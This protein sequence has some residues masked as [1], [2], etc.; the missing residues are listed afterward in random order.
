MTTP[1]AVSFIPWTAL[2]A[3]G[4]ASTQRNFAKLEQEAAKVSFYSDRAISGPLQT[5]GYARAVLNE[6]IGLYQTPDDLDQGVEARTDRRHILEN[7]DKRIRIILHE[8]AL[9][10]RVG[11]PAVMVGQMRHLVNLIVRRPP[12]LTLGILPRTTPYHP[13]LA[14]GGFVLYDNRALCQE[15]PVGLLT[16]TRPELVDECL[17]HHGY[18]T[19]RSL[20]RA[21]AVEAT[22]RALSHWRH[23]M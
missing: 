10:Q 3:A 16:L 6:A 14:G 20:Y 13:S 15:T 19:S 18:L 12:A 4:Q 17:R 8:D 22:K 7:P 21:P 5:R 11:D 1:D 2:L 23:A 9:Y